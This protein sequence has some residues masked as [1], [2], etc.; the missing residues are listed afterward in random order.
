MVATNRWKHTTVIPFSLVIQSFHHLD[1]GEK[2]SVS[3]KM[4][5]DEKAMN[6]RQPTVRGG[7]QTNSISCRRVR[8]MM[9]LATGM[10]VRIKA[11]RVDQRD[12]EIIFHYCLLAW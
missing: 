6:T 10:L 5:K 7:I 12:F 11:G 4:I 9:Y 3:A 8:R 1:R 2:N